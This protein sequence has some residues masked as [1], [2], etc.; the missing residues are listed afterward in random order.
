MLRRALLIAALAAAPLGAQEQ[1]VYVRTPGPGEATAVIQDVL[2][3]PYVVRHE[4]WNTRLFRDSVFDRSV[5]IVGSNATV[6]STVHGD[7]LVVGGDLFLRPGARIDGRAIAVGGGV[8][9]SA[10]ATVHGEELAF[11]DTRFV[12]ERTPEGTALDYQR[13][14]PLEE[15]EGLSFPLPFGFRQPTY[16]RVDGLSVPWGPRLA[17]GGGRVVIDPTVAYRSDIGAFDPS[18][19]ITFDVG[20]GW[21]VDAL[22]ERATLTNDDWIQ[23]NLANSLAVLVTGHDYR[24]YWR[25]DLFEGRLAHRWEGADGTM[26]LWG[27]A[28]TERDWPISAGG[29]WSIAGQRVGDGIHRPNPPAERGRLSSALGG[30]SGELQLPQLTVQGTITVERAFDAPRDE[31]FTQGTLHLTVAFPTFA[32]QTFRFRSHVVLTDGD[33]APV[34]RQ[35]HLGGW[36]TLPTAGLLTMGGDRLAFFE[37]IY[38]VPIEPIRVSLLG[39]PVVSL[40]YMVGSA[41]VQRLPKFG[42]N[43]GVRLALGPGRVDYVFDPDTREHAWGVGL[44]IMH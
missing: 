10:Q 44:T 42:Q 41:G 22:G 24:D 19:A 36:G 31:R 37:G 11:R 23:T 29:P 25:G 43:L 32:T 7:V 20:G 33:T 14:S 26:E 1:R 18:L 8:Y 40:R 13:P 38:D 15:V 5:V 6:A 16:T 9:R 12:A 4:R 30:V 39:S 21:R 27:G 34:Q 28:R 35:A 3:H 17:L 2:A